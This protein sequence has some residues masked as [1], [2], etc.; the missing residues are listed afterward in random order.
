MTKSGSNSE[1]SGPFVK[2]LPSSLSGPSDRTARRFKGTVRELD[3]GVREF[4]LD[5][6]S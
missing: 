6:E 5:G 1:G 2:D 3:L 4:D